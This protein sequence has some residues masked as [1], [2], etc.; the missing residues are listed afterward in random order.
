MEVRK[1]STIN[2][3]EELGLKEETVYR[4]TGH[5]HDDVK[6]IIRKAREGSLAKFLHDEST[7]LIEEILRAIHRAGFI[8]Y[9][10]EETRAIRRLMVELKIISAPDTDANSDEAYES[11]VSL[12][13]KAREEIKAV[14]LKWS[15]AMAPDGDRAADDALLSQSIEILK[16]PER[17]YNILML[18]GITTVG[19]LTKMTMSDLLRMRGVGHKLA[20]TIRD[21]LDAYCNIRMQD[22]D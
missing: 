8:T 18:N 7:Y 3:L 22:D 15:S 4:L 9:E 6:T 1:I 12:P 11:S 13:K 20:T 14:L 21:R 16:L 19:D 5:G 2:S 17:P 10:D